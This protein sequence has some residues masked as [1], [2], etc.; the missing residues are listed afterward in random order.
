MAGD[1]MKL[2]VMMLFA[3]QKVSLM[4]VA[5]DEMKLTVMM[6]VA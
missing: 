4:M 5:G 2:T 3:S 6:L 1:E